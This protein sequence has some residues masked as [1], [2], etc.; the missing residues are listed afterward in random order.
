MS[1][2]SGYGYVSDKAQAGQ[3]YDIRPDTVGS[4]AAQGIVPFGV[5]LT[6]GTDKDNQCDIIDNSGDKFLGVSLFTHATE[7]G[8]VDGSAEYAD[9][10]TVSVLRQGAVWVRVTEAVAA[11]DAA[12]VE[13][14]GTDNG[15][16]NKT[17]SGNV[18][19]PNG[20][21]LTSA[22]A[23]ELAVLEIL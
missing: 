18:A 3:K 19:V 12:Y 11:G 1:Q 7:N 10:D 2:T 14:G 9:T 22:S 20:K 21:Y 6:Y 8:A 16:F 17:S 4:Y 13:V 5:G 15:K 23:G